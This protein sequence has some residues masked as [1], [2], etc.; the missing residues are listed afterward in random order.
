MQPEPGHTPKA[1][2]RIFL[3]LP[4]W[5][6][7]ANAPACCKKCIRSHH[8][9]Q[10]IHRLIDKNSREW[11]IKQLAR[12]AAVVQI[13]HAQERKFDSKRDEKSGAPSR[14]LVGL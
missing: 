7:S 11:P 9:G 2:R 6:N 10:A 12:L 14:D 8:A 13:L 4:I 3:N 1:V 5:G